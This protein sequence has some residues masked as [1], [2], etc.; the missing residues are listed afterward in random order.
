MELVGSSLYYYRRVI[1][2]DTV[3]LC[4]RTEKY[5]EIEIK[6]CSIADLIDDAYGKLCQRNPTGQ[7]GNWSACTKPA[8]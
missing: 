3:V 1:P 2:P 8:H 6:T 4:R 7:Y 5:Y